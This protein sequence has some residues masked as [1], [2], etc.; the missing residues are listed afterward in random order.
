MFEETAVS[1][2]SIDGHSDAMVIFLTGNITLDLAFRFTLGTYDR[3]DFSLCYTSDA[4]ATFSKST[5]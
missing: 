2:K 5:K 3:L 1:K 4:A